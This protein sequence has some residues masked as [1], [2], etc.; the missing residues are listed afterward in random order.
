MHNEPKTSEVDFSDHFLEMAFR[1]DLRQRPDRAHGYGKKER[2]CGDA[3]EVF[4]SV[5]D[6]IIVKLQYYSNGCFSTNACGN[7]LAELAV[8]QSIAKARDI[9]PEVITAFLE[10]LPAHEFHCA[11]MAADALLLA[12]ADYHNIK[13]KPWE[14]DYRSL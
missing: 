14:K 11:E 13:Q 5:H 2:E 9:T 10:T 6:D 4:L 12:L 1:T 8:G 3:L 7:A